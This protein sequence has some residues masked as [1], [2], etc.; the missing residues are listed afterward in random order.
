MNKKEMLAHLFSLGRWHLTGGMHPPRSTE[1]LNPFGKEID[2]YRTAGSLKFGK[3]RV[4]RKTH[5]CRAGQRGEAVKPQTGDVSEGGH[6][7]TKSSA[8]GSDL[9]GSIAARCFSGSCAEL[10]FWIQ[11]KQHTHGRRHA[12]CRLSAVGE[13]VSV[14]SN[15]CIAHPKLKAPSPTGKSGRRW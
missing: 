2:R 5:I 1:G 9:V 12:Q 11:T 14:F 7:M 3:H 4:T 6:G 8:L 13:F 10:G 15:D